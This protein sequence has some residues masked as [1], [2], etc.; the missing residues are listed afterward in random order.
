SE[1]PRYGL[2]M[3]ANDVGVDEFRADAE[4]FL[5]ASIADGVAFKAFGAILPPAIFEPTRAWQRR[6]F[7]AGFAGVHWP[8]EHGGRGLSS[9]HAAA[10]AEECARRGVASYMNFQGF[11]LAGAAI[12]KFG[13]DA[14]KE[15]Y[16]RDT[17]AADIIWCQLFSEPNSGSDLASLQTRAVATDGGWLV[18][19]QKVW[20]STAQL[21]DHAILMARTD[22][23]EPS[24]RGISFFLFDMNQEAVDVRP[25]K[26][27]TGDW[28]FC[29]VFLEDAFISHDDL[30]GPLNAGWSVAMSVLADERASVGA[31][32]LALQRQLTDVADMAGIS[33]SA[34]YGA[35][36]LMSIG[37]AVGRLLS[38]SGGDPSLGPLTKLARTE[39][40]R[41]LTA[42][43]NDVRGP[44]GMLNSEAGQA[45][46][47]APGMRVAGGTSEIQR[48][49]VGERMLGLP[50]EPK[51]PTSG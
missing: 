47:Y 11:I 50:R 36:D 43:M 29:E 6:I 10:W 3:A 27:M 14:Q 22:P 7:E 51:P 1:A 28:E 26:Q 37:G 44:A 20:S 38:R 30:L 9:D 46:L 39:L 49:L 15:R 34:R 2:A 8:A 41:G 40:D 33:Q 32:G 4:R 16:L 13:T 45:F 35:V 5:D 23:D 12:I 21:S 19:G 17:L 48:N 31:A 24:H 25:L 42:Y 18:N